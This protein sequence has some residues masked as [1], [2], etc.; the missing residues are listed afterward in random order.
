[1]PLIP[2]LVLGG[3]LDLV[4][5]HYFPGTP[6]VESARRISLPIFLGNIAFLQGIAVPY[7]GSNTPLWSLAFEGWFYLAFPLLLIAGMRLR[8]SSAQ[9]VLAGLLAIAVY[10]LV[11]PIFAFYFILWC[12]GAA[13]A[14]LPRRIPARL[15][16]KLIPAAVMGFLIMNLLAWKFQPYQLMTD[17]L[18]AASAAALCYLLLHAQGP[19]RGG[20]YSATAVFLARM[21]YTLYLAHFPMVSFLNCWLD[22]SEQPWPVTPTNIAIVLGWQMLVFA[23]CYLLYRAFEANTDKVRGW[24]ALPKLKI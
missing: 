11:G 1:M 6:A 23:L 16:P 12:F 22:P 14:V 19:A 10:G 17:P 7:L 20:R 24:L 3:L 21:F 4:A 2:I 15:V 18:L 5:A 8:S 13:V 9:A